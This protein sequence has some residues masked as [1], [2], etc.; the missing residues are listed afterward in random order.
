MAYYED[1][2]EIEFEVI[3]DRPTVLK[4]TKAASRVGT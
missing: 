3:K 2:E 1:F 4:T